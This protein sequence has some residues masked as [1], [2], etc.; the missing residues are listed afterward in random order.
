MP[1]PQFAGVMF[2]RYLWEGPGDISDLE[3]ASGY[4]RVNSKSCLSLGSI[5]NSALPLLS[6]R[7][8]I[9][10]LIYKVPATEL[11]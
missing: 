9:S 10:S 11:I 7:A 5:I 1:L 4:D 8:A 2:F 3:T 6:N